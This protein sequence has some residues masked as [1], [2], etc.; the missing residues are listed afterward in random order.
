MES[1]AVVGSSAMM[2]RGE[3]ISA[4]AMPHALLLAAGQFVRVF[5]GHIE[6][7]PDL[8]QQGIHSVGSFDLG[9]IIVQPQWQGDLLR[10]GHHRV[11]RGSRILEHRTHIP[12]AQV[13]KR[14]FGSSDNFRAAHINRP[15]SHSGQG[16]QSPA[17]PWQS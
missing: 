9:Q 16:Q 2:N 1:S 14:T 17:S 5:A 15:I 4:V 8:A 13:G 3:V 6:I 12:A 7:Q 10:H 11:Q